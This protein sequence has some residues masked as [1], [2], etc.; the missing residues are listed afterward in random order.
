MAEHGVGRNIGENSAVSARSRVYLVSNGAT[1]SV[2]TVINDG[3][4]CVYDQI[5]EIEQLLIDRF[6]DL[7]FDFNVIAR[8]GR[9]ISEILG[10]HT[11]AWTRE[12]ANLYPDVTNI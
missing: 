12:S 4:E 8:R 3:S 6:A 1:L 2:F 5:Y 10:A 7:H 9:S 11:P